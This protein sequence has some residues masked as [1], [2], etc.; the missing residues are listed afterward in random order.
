MR[1]LIAERQQFAG[2]PADPF[3]PMAGLKS[4]P[5]DLAEDTKIAKKFLTERQ[6]VG[7][8]FLED[9]IKRPAL[10]EEMT[11]LAETNLDKARRV[12]TILDTQEAHFNDI[13]ESVVS[14]AFRTT[15][16]NAF[17]VVQ[18]GFGQANRG[19]IFHEFAMQTPQ[20]TAFYLDSTY[21]TTTR[22]ATAGNRMYEDP[23]FRYAAAQ[24][25]AV[26][27]TGNG[28][29]TTFTLNAGTVLVPVRPNSC[30]MVYIPAAGVPE[31]VA[32]DDR[33][34]GNFVQA[35][36]NKVTL[37]GANTI[38]Y[39]TGAVTVTFTAA[40]AAGDVI[41]LEYAFSAE[42][43]T[44]YTQVQEVSLALRAYQ[45]ALREFPL[46][47]VVSNM[48]KMLLTG[49][50]N[51]EAQEAI[52]RNAGGELS[53]SLDF[54]S[55]DLAMKYARANGA[56]TTMNFT[57]AV[58]ESEIDRAQ[59]IT[60]YIGQT[61]NAMYKAIQRGS[62]AKIVGGPAAVELLKLHA[63]FTNA[64]E[65]PANNVFKTGSID[66]MDIYKAPVSLIPDDE[67]LCIY[68]NPEVPE[69]VALAIG[70]YVPMY[71]SDPLT[72]KSM[73]TEQGVAWYGDQK[74]LQPKYLQRLVISNIP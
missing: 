6:I 7:D 17:R 27:G 72:F 46:Y 68:K 9:W 29:L 44:N 54:Y 60:R 70:T 20:D 31:I 18:L 47:V 19:E 15:P 38:D 48:T 12:A 33:G 45:F 22:G 71:I 61:A 32:T 26:V 56:P 59:S 39:N 65:Q 40:P 11:K 58:G 35:S 66:G 55:I 25:Y 73:Q 30:K 41:R 49:T 63:R 51:I 34:T 28:I 5:A 14:T 3:G 16:E 8:R 1:S 13:T 64:G 43:P 24:E 50:L 52:V 69:D 53:K 62:V 36:T 57:G 23:A 74:V 21:A 10:A 2:K 67:L 37:T 42:N 4:T